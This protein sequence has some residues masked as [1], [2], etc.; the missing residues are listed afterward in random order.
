M[1]AHNA[2]RAM[3]SIAQCWNATGTQAPFTL[4]LSGRTYAIVAW[5]VVTAFCAIV[6]AGEPQEG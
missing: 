1:A 6:Y 3:R 5:V 4:A 2:T